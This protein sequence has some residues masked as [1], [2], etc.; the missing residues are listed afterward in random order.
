MTIIKIMTTASWC[1]PLKPLW[2]RTCDL[3]THRS[4]TCVVYPKRKRFRLDKIDMDDQLGYPKRL[5]SGHRERFRAEHDVAVCCKVILVGPLVL[6]FGE[7]RQH[8]IDVW[9][10]RVLAEPL[11]EQSVP[12]V[13]HLLELLQRKTQ[14]PSGNSAKSGACVYT[15]VPL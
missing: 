2:T 11:A 8:I 12:E 3:D 4:Q 1:K 15:P 14:T 5:Q 9:Q 13:F 6:R 10:R 7:P